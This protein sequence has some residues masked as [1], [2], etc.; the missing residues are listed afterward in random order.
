M[1]A[2]SAPLTAPTPATPTWTFALLAFACGA[3]VA[4]LYYAQPLI[5]LIAADTGLSVAAAG[6]MVTL[7]QIGYGLG[8]L[9]LVPLGDLLAPAK[10]IASLMALTVL[11]LVNAALS[12]TA[13][14]F[15][16]SSFLVGV[17]CCVAQVLVPFGAQLAP[18]ASRGKAVGQ[19]MSGL[20]FGILLARPVSSLLAS[21]L[22]WH[23]VFWVSAVVIG[24]LAL[25][26]YRLL[27]HSRTAAPSAVAQG[28]AFSRYTALLGSLWPLL[29]DT[30]LLQRRAAYQ[31]GMFGA[32][33]LFWTTVPLLLMSPAY[34]YTQRGVALFALMGA[35]GALVAPWAGR[36]AD[37]GWTRRLTGG[38]LVS[39]VLAWLVGLLATPG[40]PVA[41]AALLVAALVLD[42]AV[43]ITLITGQR[44]IYALGDAIRSR[45]NAL[46][47]ALFFVGGALGSALGA[48][49]WAHGGWPQV[50]WVGLGFPAAALVVYLLAEP[51]N[52][53]SK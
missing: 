44:G 42:M 10:L 26:L 40:G 23:A 13:P 36:L 12:T 9:F 35:G 1:Q 6:S 33:S 15:L 29:R 53:P 22:G 41:L 2:P 34:G 45:L 47:M 25:V 14:Q 43:A 5:S 24:V 39:G 18:P 17:S 30:P 27:P 38:A 20:L 19:I 4:N 16:L 32:F 37:K 7:T 46:F 31:A 50:S 3:I 48:W 49:A 28:S 21:L 52:P 51:R 8:V 11:A